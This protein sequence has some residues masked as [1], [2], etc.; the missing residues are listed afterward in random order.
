MSFFSGLSI[1]FYVTVFMLIPYCFWWYSFVIWFE[2]RKCDYLQF[3]S[4]FS[5]FPWLFDYPGSCVAIGWALWLPRFSGQS[6]WVDRTGDSAQQVSRTPWLVWMVDWRPKS[7]ITANWTLAR[8]DH[9]SALQMGR[10]TGWDL[11]LDTAASRNT[12]CQ[13]LK[14]IALSPACL[15]LTPSGSVAVCLP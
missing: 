9:C 1:L 5:R 12:V 8:G 4:S 15:L 11:C 6:F 14:L 7:G 13:H 3:Y 2:I 10:G